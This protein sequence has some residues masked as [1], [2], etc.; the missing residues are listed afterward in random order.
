M[1]LKLKHNKNN[2]WTHFKIPNP[3]IQ[4]FFCKKKTHSTSHN[5]SKKTLLDP[6]HKI[7]TNTKKLLSTLFKSL[8]HCLKN[9]QFST[10]HF[11]W[12]YIRSDIDLS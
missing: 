6:K 11:F 3:K 8:C 9:F 1:N 12:D 7:H 4:N 10:F 5:L 2:P